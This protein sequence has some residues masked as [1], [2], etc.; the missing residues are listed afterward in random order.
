MKNYFPGFFSPTRV[1]DLT[2]AAHGFVL[3]LKI[4]LLSNHFVCEFLNYF[5][6]G[7]VPLTMDLV[8]MI[9]SSVPQSFRF[10]AIL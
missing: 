3:E 1:Y 8:V 10:F 9:H 2:D 6:S 4:F 5:F 7:P